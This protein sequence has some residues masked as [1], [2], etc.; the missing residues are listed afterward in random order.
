M[1]TLEEIEIAIYKMRQELHIILDKKGNLLDTEVII[2]S[3]ELD[4][5]LNEYNMLIK[6]KK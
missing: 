4:L 5:M 6:K 1:Y 2:A 3:Q